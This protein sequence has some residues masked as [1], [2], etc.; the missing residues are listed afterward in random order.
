MN[1]ITSYKETISW[2]Q[3]ILI[4]NLTYEFVHKF[5][6]EYSR[7]DHM[8]RSARSMKQNIAEGAARNSIQDNIQFIGYS[9]ASGEELLEDFKDIA[10]LFKIPIWLKFDSRLNSVSYFSISSISSYSREHAL[11]LLI[12]LV[13]KTNYLLDQQRRGLE[14]RFIEQGGYTENLAK[15]RREYRGY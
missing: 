12:D 8:V 3:V 14:K 5:N 2:N 13:T 6:I 1:K 15:K 7:A 4:Q 9:R 11:N 10:F